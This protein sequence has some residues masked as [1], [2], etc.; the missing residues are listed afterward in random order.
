LKAN[1]AALLANLE[2][3]GAKWETKIKE[4]KDDEA[5]VTFKKNCKQAESDL[6]AA[7]ATFKKSF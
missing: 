2:A 6:E 4:G 3:N 7:I 1:H 5:T